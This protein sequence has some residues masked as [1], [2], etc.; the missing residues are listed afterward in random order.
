MNPRIRKIG[1]GVMEKLLKWGLENNE[2]NLARRLVY[3][4]NERKFLMMGKMIQI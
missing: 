4:W 2:I 3:K 1:V